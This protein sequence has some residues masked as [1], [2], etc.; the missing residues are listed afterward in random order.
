MT[1]QEILDQLK[2][3][4]QSELDA[5]KE[6]YTWDGIQKSP[7]RVARCESHIKTLEDTLTHIKMLEDYEPNTEPVKE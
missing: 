6:V 4:V 5:S 2:R 3:D 7:V 1:A